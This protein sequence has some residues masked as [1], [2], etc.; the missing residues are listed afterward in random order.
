M[1]FMGMGEFGS[2][3][4][5]LMFVWA[6]FKDHFPHRLRLLIEKYIE[7]LVKFVCPYI[8]ITFHEFYG[9]EY[10]ERSKAF[11]DIQNYLSTKATSQASKFKADVVKGSK[12]LILT[13]D[14]HEEVPDEFNGVKVWWVLHKHETNSKSFSYYP[15]SN[16]KRY[17]KLSFH[18]KHRE[19]ITGSYIDHVI[20]EGKN[21]ASTN[22]KRKLYSNNPSKDW[23]SGWKNSKW[24]HVFFEHPATFE[25]L[26]METKKKDIIKEDL[27][28]F[29]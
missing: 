17:F 23:Y 15:A 13:M 8:E 3:L 16:E 19:L 14:D 21:V 4:A 11:S 6:I 10:M 29:T 5:S 1:G 7:K 9:G 18:K 22:R 25:T 28:K 27:K 24:S 26:A 12:S 20:K 2:V